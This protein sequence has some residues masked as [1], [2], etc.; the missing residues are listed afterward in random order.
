MKSY[1]AKPITLLKLQYLLYFCFV[2]L[3][4]IKLYSLITDKRRRYLSKKP[5]VK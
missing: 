2:Q 1:I 5:F 4:T 3:I